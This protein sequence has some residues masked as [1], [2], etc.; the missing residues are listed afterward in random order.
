MAS[1]PQDLIYGLDDKPPLA[2]LL[3]IGCQHIFLMSSTLVLPIVLITEIGGTFDE[4]RSVI[5]LTMI[6]C[7]I[8]TIVQALR[9]RFIGSG[10][11]CP[12]LCGPNFFAASMEAAWLGGLP[13]MR[14]MTIIAGIA[15]AL[16]SRLAHRL[17]F[18]FP[19]EITGLV[20]LMVA[21]GL[22]TLGV[23]KFLGITYEGEP[24]QSD[25]VLIA[26]ITLLIMIG[27]NIWSRGNLRL[28]S[29]FLGFA[30]G[31]LLSIVHGVLPLATLQ[32]VLNVPWVA[33]PFLKNT[34]Q[35]SF[36]WSLVPLFVIVSITGALK[37]FGNLIMCEKINDPAWKAPN[38]RR[39]SNGLLA[40]SISVTT[41]GLLGGVASDTSASNVALSKASGATS[42]VIAY[43][44]GGLFILLAFFP[45]VSGLLSAMPSPVMGAILIYVSSF[46]IISGMQ[47]ILGSGI[48]TSKTF[49]IGIPLIF[50]MSLDIAPSL[51]AGVPHL[52]RPLFESSLTLST[53][54]AVLLHQ[55]VRVGSR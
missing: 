10:F 14:G 21:Q 52:L 4:V 20:V 48:D 47:I 28:Y 34:L 13:L 31:Y 33:L 17:A 30:S 39:V 9:W 32:D 45:K 23:S 2:D 44:A 49:V 37:S 6:A 51:F 41:S 50:G 12:N 22:V 15:E 43:V 18:L 16:F 24:I 53:V 26:S 38:M 27:V 19:P 7:G 35:V 11:L 1:K 5:A 36:D 29:V 54:M 3:I 46:M 55:L 42:R 40:D 25:S 8:G